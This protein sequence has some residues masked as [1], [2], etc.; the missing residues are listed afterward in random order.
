M[1]VRRMVV[2]VAAL[3][4]TALLG[5]R[6]ITKAHVVKLG[7]TDDD[8]PDRSAHAPPS[9]ALSQKAPDQRPLVAPPSHVPKFTTVLDSNETVQSNVVKVRPVADL[10][11]ALQPR[12]PWDGPRPRNLGEVQDLDRVKEITR[13]R[14]G[15]ADYKLRFLSAMSDCVDPKAISVGAIAIGLVFERDRQTGKFVGS[16]IRLEQS[17]VDE[18]DDLLFLECAREAHIGKP[19]DYDPQGTNEYFMMGQYSVPLRNDLYYAALAGVP[20]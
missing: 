16:D 5:V 17:T 1:R 6:V 9:P 2:A 10:T 14:V 12:P 3:G 8:Q 19:L 7:S 20:R 13:G 18:R 4:S 15:L 11:A